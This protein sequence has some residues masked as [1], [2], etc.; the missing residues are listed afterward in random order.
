MRS[1]GR[2]LKPVAGTSA[3]L[4]TGK[5]LHGVDQHRQPQSLGL[6][7]SPTLNSRQLKL[8]AHSLSLSAGSG[9]QA[10][11]N[12]R[13]AN[14]FPMRLP[15]RKSARCDLLHKKPERPALSLRHGPE[16]PPTT[17][18]PERGSAHRL[19][20]NSYRRWGDPFCADL[21]D[22]VL[23]SA[24]PWS[25]AFPPFGLGIPAPDKVQSAERFFFDRKTRSPCRSLPRAT[26]K[27]QS[28]KAAGISSPHCVNRA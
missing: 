9:N 20:L 13:A 18:R 16:N 6:C 14:R 26:V 11:I 4:R 1:N 5:L 12:P 21:S 7:G 17:V 8:L 23:T 28:N 25:G 24:E 2:Q 22:P 27:R 3:P 10:L 15:E 19:C